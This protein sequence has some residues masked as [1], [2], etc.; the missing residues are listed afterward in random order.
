[1]DLAAFPTPQAIARLVRSYIAAFGPLTEQD[2]VWW[3]GLGKRRVERALEDLIEELARLDVEGSRMLLLQSQ[4]DPLHAAGKDAIHLPV[5]LPVQD[6]YLMGYRQRARY[7]RAEDTDYVFDRAGNAT[8][9]IILQGHVAGVWDEDP[10]ARVIKYFLFQDHSTAD[11]D[12]V[13]HRLEALGEFLF[14]GSAVVQRCDQMIPLSER[15]MGSM[16]SPLRDS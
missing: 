10:K 9:V 3:T 5:P 4:V 11:E 12:H 15:T 8:S 16:M 13:R 14:E 6:S 7:L 1:M 2:V